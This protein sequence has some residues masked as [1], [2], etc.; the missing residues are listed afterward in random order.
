MSHVWT[1]GIRLQEKTPCETR[2]DQINIEH[3]TA[4]PREQQPIAADDFIR[5]PRR[6]LS[7]KMP[8]AQK[9][10][11]TPGYSFQVLMESDFLELVMKE[12][13][14]RD[15]PPMDNIISWN[16]RG[17]NCPNNHDNLKIFILKNSIGLM[18]CDK[19]SED[20]QLKPLIIEQMQFLRDSSQMNQILDLSKHLNKPLL[21]LNKDKFEDIHE[22]QNL[23]RDKLI[24][25]NRSFRMTLRI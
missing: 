1:Y 23:Y 9:G 24:R 12:A 20:P 4:H 7:S 21:N 19:W 17:L 11:H 10:V 8:N 5:I 15:I 13:S 2:M 22:Q 16:I 3:A 6:S 18:F 25:F 14:I